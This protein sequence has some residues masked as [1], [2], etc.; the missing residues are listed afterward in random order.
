[1]E[2]VPSECFVCVLATELTVLD[3]EHCN[4]H[5]HCHFKATSPLNYVL[6]HL[7][8]ELS[9]CDNWDVKTYHSIHCTLYSDLMLD[10]VAVNHI[11]NWLHHILEFSRVN[12]SWVN[13]APPPVHKQRY[14]DAAEG[15]ADVGPIWKVFVSKL[16]ARTFFWRDFCP[17][18]LHLKPF[19]WGGTGWLRS[20]HIQLPLWESITQI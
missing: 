1:M 5:Q 16:L 17:L 10:S 14:V 3:E 19:G 15:I 8:A 13:M 9:A 11:P 4:N 18:L 20:F 12:T 2:H 7:G 6:F